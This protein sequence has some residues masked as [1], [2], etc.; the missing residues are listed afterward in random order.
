MQELYKLLIGVAVLILGIPIGNLLAKATKEELKEGRIWFKT[1]VAVCLVCGVVSLIFQN[2]S[3]LF[4][5]LFI[6]IVA[7]RSLKK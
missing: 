2:D 3:L 6:A 4:G 7:S 5:F 1:L